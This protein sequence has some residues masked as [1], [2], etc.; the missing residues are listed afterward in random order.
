MDFTAL[1]ANAFGAIKALFG[2]AKQRDAE[3]NSP[4]MEQA[5]EAKLEAAAL[6]ATREAI[7]K[8]DLDELRKEAAE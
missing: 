7:A 2:F 5:K 6:D 8:K 4:A 3:K 1:I